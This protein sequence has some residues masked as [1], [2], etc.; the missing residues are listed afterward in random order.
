MSAEP[1]RRASR[2]AVRRSDQAG[3]HAY[4]SWFHGPSDGDGPSRAHPDLAA[5]VLALV[6][7]GFGSWYLYRHDRGHDQ[8]A[9]LHVALTS[10]QSGTCRQIPG[11]DGSGG[12][13]QSVAAACQIAYHRSGSQQLPD[14][15]APSAATVVRAANARSERIECRDP[16]VARWAFL[17]RELNLSHT[18]VTT[19]P[20]LHDLTALRKLDLSYAPIAVLP[21]LDALTCAAGTRPVAHQCRDAA[22]TGRLTELRGST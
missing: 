3:W 17:L 6:I 2:T 15:D 19:L 5:A 16:R 11:D 8:L 20:P 4:A 18:K 21:P 22:T 9:A 1:V 13:S 12:F 10:N 7:V 14:C